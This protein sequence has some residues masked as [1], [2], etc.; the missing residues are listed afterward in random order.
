M[1]FTR[2]KITTTVPLENADAVRHALGEAGA[3]VIGNYSFCSFSVIG[4]GWFMP[5]E[6]ANPHI[7][8]AN[9]LE[10]VEEERVE[11]VCDRKNAKQ[12]IVALKAAHSYEEVIVD[13]TP[14]IDE[15]QL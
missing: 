15:D 12:V 9:V 13:I 4:K 3:G 11:V 6:D 5:N 1:N 2:V 14:L 8:S 10:A 7:G